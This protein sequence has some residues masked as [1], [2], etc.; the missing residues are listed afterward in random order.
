MKGELFLCIPST[1]ASPPTDSKVISGNEDIYMASRRVV[2]INSR[3]NILWHSGDY[4]LLFSA[5]LDFSR[6]GQ[7]WSKITEKLSFRR[8]IFFLLL[9]SFVLSFSICS[10][11]LL[12]FVVGATREGKSVVPGG[13][14]SSSPSSSPLRVQKRHFPRCT[15]SS[16]LIFI[17]RRRFRLMVDDDGRER[18][19]RW[20]PNCCF[21]SLEHDPST[22]T[23]G[24]FGG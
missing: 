21:I 11:L 23:E 13:F 12:L 3:R 10:F 9:S 5:A 2:C 22:G 18:R 4:F 6:A 19:R 15:R 17:L 20:W 14:F 16:S 7:G 24:F 1:V 8:Q